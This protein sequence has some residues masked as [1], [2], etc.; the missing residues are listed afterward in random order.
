MR[1]Y[2]IYTSAGEDANVK[3]WAS[4]K[5]RNYDIWVTNYTDQPG[6]NK[7]YADYYN[8]HVGTKIPNLY[9]VF[10]NHPDIL[11]QY[12]AIMVADDDVLISPRW[13]SRLFKLSVDYDLWMLQPAFSHFGKISH[14]LTARRLNSELRFVNFVEITCPIFPMDKL[15]DFLSVYS[16]DMPSIAGI[17]YRLPYFYGIE[18]ENKY[19]ISDSWYCI[20]PREQFKPHHK[21]AIDRASSQASR[22]NMIATT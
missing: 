13:L 8:E 9:D 22:K 2:L 1:E 5:S 20:N 18:R 15:M 4:S 3:V 10:L 16:L 19:A 11:R 14:P 21:H 6:L 12:K 7:E 17:D